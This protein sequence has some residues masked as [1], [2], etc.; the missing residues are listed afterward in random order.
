MLLLKFCTFVLQESE[1]SQVKVATQVHS[2]V[3]LP[4]G[5][6]GVGQVCHWLP[7]VI[8]Q[9]ST[10]DWQP[11]LPWN[12]ASIALFLM[13]LFLSQASPWTKDDW[14]ALMA[15]VACSSMAL[16]LCSRQ[17][18]TPCVTWRTHSCWECW[19]ETTS[20]SLRDTVRGI[21]QLLFLTSRSHVSFIMDV[22][23]HIAVFD[24]TYTL[25][26]KDSTPSV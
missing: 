1:T 5:V 11:Y 13:G 20:G 17:E 7:Q 22:Q 2:Q 24:L 6:P 25:Y 21:T 19:Q 3:P 16:M 9:A 18:C 14:G 26:L 10:E 4:K 15:A 23:Y 8:L 12:T